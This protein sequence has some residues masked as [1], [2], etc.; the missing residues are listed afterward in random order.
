MMK[1]W[2]FT[3]LTKIQSEVPD[4]KRQAII[5]IGSVTYAMKAKDLLMNK[6]GIRAIVEKNSL[7]RKTAGCSY[8]LYIKGNIEEA[9]KILI[10]NGIK[11]NGI[12]YGND[13][14]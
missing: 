1:F 7:S 14:R 4:M 2:I 3:L 6:Y 5:S 12:I 13:D 9:H 10:A 11:T 8:G